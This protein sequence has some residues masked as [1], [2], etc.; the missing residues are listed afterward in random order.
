MPPESR[1]I[2]YTERLLSDTF[3]SPKLSLHFSILHSYQA[4]LSLLS[5]PHRAAPQGPPGSLA[6]RPSPY[7]GCHAQVIRPHYEDICATLINEPVVLPLS[8]S[9]LL[10]LSCPCL[11]SGCGLPPAPQPDVCPCTVA[12]T[13][14]QTSH[15]GR[16]LA[17]ECWQLIWLHLHQEQR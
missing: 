1:R 7:R 6:A 15:G 16:A 8:T 10:P 2:H 11:S 12:T 5:F 14:L 13:R 17:A 4:A 9:P 3:H